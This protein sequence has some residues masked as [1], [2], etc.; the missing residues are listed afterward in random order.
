MPDAPGVRI[1]RGLRS[2]DGLSLGD[3]FGERFFVNPAA[4]E[5][6]IVERAVP[7]APW[8]WTDDTEMALAIVEVLDAHRGIESAEV[9]HAHPESR[10]G[11]IAVAIAAAAATRGLPLFDVVLAH[12]PSGETR[13]GIERAA[14]LSAS[15]SVHLAASE[16]GTGARMSAMDTVPFSIWAAHRHLD[17]FEDAMWTTVAGLGDRDTTCAIVGSIVAMSAPPATL[18]E[19]WKEAREP[20]EEDPVVERIL[21]RR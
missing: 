1:A 13:A 11:A 5:A 21:A 15:A 8:F 9:T 7:A 17:H 20:V 18:P 3:A 16:L 10:A 2:L 19:A 14:R 4:V 12:T 6:L